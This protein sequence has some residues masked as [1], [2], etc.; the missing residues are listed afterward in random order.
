MPSDLAVLGLLERLPTPRPA[1]VLM[2]AR[3]AKWTEG[4]GMEKMPHNDKVKT[5]AYNGSKRMRLRYRSRTL[6][7]MWSAVRSV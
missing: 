6:C 4:E 2:P 7:L 3:M 1:H 5:L